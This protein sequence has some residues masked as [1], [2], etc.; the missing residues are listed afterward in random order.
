[1]KDMLLTLTKYVLPGEFVDYFDLVDIIEKE[2]ELHL[3]LE[4]KNSIPEKFSDIHLES[5]GFYEASTIWALAERPLSM[6]R[7]G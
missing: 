6:R 4:E 7:G 3:Y 2:E 1:M 5:N